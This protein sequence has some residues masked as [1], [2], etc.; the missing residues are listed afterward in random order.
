MYIIVGLGN[1]GREYQNTRHNVGYMTLDILADRMNI[2][3]KRH[4]FRAVFGE[5]C[6]G[7]TKV[8]LAKPETYMNLSGW[9]VMELCNWYKPEHDQLIVIYD[10]IDIP[11]G[12]I[13]IRGNGSAGTHNGMRNIVYQ[14]GYD[15]FPRIRVGIGRADGERTLVSHVLGSPEG[16]E[17]DMLIRAMNDA[18]DAAELMIKGEMKEAQ[19]RFNKKPKKEKKPKEQQREEKS[20]EG[21]APAPEEA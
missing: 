6:L 1:P 13:R 9:S 15:D 17:R 19:A 10:D 3:I 14:L 2:E 11:L 8:V 7:G 4:N 20:A 5:G 21:E 12:T 18:A 16:E